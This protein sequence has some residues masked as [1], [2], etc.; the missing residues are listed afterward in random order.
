[1]SKELAPLH[2]VT[3]SAPSQSKI[4]GKI[5]SGLAAVN[6]M[7]AGIT[8]CATDDM[9]PIATVDAGAS[10]SMDVDLNALQ[11]EV[12][13]GKVIWDGYGKVGWNPK[14]QELVMIPKAPVGPN[15]EHA[16][17]VVSNQIFKQP[18]RMSFTMNTMAQLRTGA[19]PGQWE[20]G[21]AVFG[22][23]ENGK[24]KYAT[25][26]T[27][28]LEIGESLLDDAQVFPYTAPFVPGIYPI[29]VDY[30]Q[31]IEVRDNVIS[32]TVNGEKIKDYTMFAPGSTD[33]LK[34]DGRVGFY[35][36]DAAVKVSNIVF[37]QL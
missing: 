23:E 31:I 18:F 20:V 8:G 14:L 3:T 1:M 27:N 35:S 21:W 9:R 32:I 34:P 7:V 16:A 17:L 5:A 30:R 37:E 11:S 25:L 33:T 28:G 6:L 12:P 2:V 22:Y 36:E 10:P 13:W 24:F 29:G 15:E 26:K 19:K 4:S